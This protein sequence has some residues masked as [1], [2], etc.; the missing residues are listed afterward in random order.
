MV[1]VDVLDKSSKNIG[2]SAPSMLLDKDVRT[3]PAEQLLN[4]T[5]SSFHM[6]AFITFKKRRL[7][8]SS[9]ERTSLEVLNKCHENVFFFQSRIERKT[10]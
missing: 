7:R 10:L 5:V 9:R 3:S 2:I 8:S 6:L 4:F 1:N